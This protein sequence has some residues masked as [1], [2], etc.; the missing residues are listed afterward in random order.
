MRCFKNI[1]KLVHHKRTTHPKRYSQS[2]LSHLMGYK[3]GQFTN[4][5]ERGLCNVPLKMMRRISEILDIPYTD[6]KLAMLEDFEQTLNHYLWSERITEHP[7]RRGNMGTKALINFKD[8]DS[9]PHA[10]SIYKHWDGYPS[11]T[12]PFIFHF[13]KEYYNNRGADVEYAVA[14]F[15]RWT[16]TKGK[17]FGL[18]MSEFTGWGVFDKHAPK[19]GQ[20]YTYTINLGT[21]TVKIGRVVVDF[22]DEIAVAQ[23]LNQCD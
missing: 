11:A 6:L 4:N 18:D 7:N 16:I 2:E 17:E 23:Y 8:E 9:K 5:V 20:E 19:V 1:A 10:V 14:Q 3:N 21:H 12:A 22:L 15:L 13:A